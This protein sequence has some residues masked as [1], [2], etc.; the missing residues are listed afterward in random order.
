MG[1]DAVKSNIVLD[2]GITFTLVPLSEIQARKAWR[3]GKG[4]SRAASRR[5]SRRQTPTLNL[6]HIFT[7]PN[8]FADDVRK[9]FIP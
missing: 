9:A 6:W 1:C 2:K 3:R 7:I 5:R 8:P 4:R